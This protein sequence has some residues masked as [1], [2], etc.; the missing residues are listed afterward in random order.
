MPHYHA[1]AWFNAVALHWMLLHG[2]EGQSYWINMD[3]VTS[4]RAPIRSDLQSSFAK[5]T[6]CIVVTSNGKFVAV[7][8]TC[9]QIYQLFEG[10]TKE[11]E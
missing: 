8:E 5:G 1:L 2:A 6:N 11:H 9:E 10:R 4:L 7:V 3:Q